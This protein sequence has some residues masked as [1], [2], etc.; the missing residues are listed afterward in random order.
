MIF[1]QASGFFRQGLGVGAAETLITQTLI[2]NAT[3]W[4]TPPRWRRSRRTR[5]AELLAQGDKKAIKEL[6]K[7]YDVRSSWWAGPPWRRP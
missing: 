3:R 1:E 7:I 4:S 5:G 2:G 6:G